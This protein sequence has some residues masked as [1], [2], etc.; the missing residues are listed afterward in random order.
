M[1]TQLQKT[2]I[3]V[4]STYVLKANS[5]PKNRATLLIKNTN[6]TII[7]VVARRNAHSIFYNP[8]NTF[9]YGNRNAV[10]L[11]LTKQKKRIRDTHA[12]HLPIQL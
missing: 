7:P 2:A 8:L 12:L 9:K 5:M 11:T 3:M 1:T 4:H 10:F 6:K